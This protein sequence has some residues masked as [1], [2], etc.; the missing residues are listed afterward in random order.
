MAHEA[1]HDDHAHATTDAKPTSSFRAAY[2]FVIVLVF[3]FIASVNFV[4]VMG[5]D[6]EAGHGGE[7]HT[8][9]AA[10]H[11]ATGHEA[12]HEEATTHEAAAPAAE[13]HVDTAVHGTEAAH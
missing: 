10:G 4:R 7:H 5:H 3:L 13:G 12:T 6:E 1:H 9:A 8:E 11:E 2:W